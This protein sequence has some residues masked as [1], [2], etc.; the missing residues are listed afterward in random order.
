[1]IKKV[2]SSIL[3]AV[4]MSSLAVG[5]GGAKP[6]D[7]SEPKEKKQSPMSR[8]LKERL[9]GG[10]QEAPAPEGETQVQPTQ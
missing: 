6:A 3:V 5:C 7:T 4:F 2:L 10:Q 9:G 8:G 1:M